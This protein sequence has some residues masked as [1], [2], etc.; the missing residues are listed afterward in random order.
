MIK[1]ALAYCGILQ[2]QLTETKVK[3]IKAFHDQSVRIVYDNDNEK[4]NQGLPSVINA[5][6]IRA[7]K[8]IRKC[9]DQNI[10]AVFKDNFKAQQHGK[11]TSNDK[12]CLKMLKIRT[13]YARKV[14]YCS[15]VK[16]YNELPLEIRFRI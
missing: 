6:K 1:P 15:G 2:L 10:C 13:E 3:Q 16:S 14:F 5:E 12:N 4:S 8:L 7:C 9:I 11:D